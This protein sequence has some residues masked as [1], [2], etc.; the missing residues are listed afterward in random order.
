MLDFLKE[1]FL[2]LLLL[3]GIL[4]LCTFI[5]SIIATIIEQNNVRLKKKQLL[6][7]LEKQ[8]SDFIKK[9]KKK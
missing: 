8:I 1:I 6:E 5:I 9:E 3:F 4:I 2:I 7:E